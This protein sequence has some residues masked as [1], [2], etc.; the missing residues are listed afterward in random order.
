MAGVVASTRAAVLMA[1]L[2]LVLAACGS[3]PPTAPTTPGRT[4]PAFQ[5]LVFTKTAGFRHPSIPDA[6]NALHRLGRDHSFAVDN[7]ADATRITDAGLARYH[8]VV[9]LSTTG[10]ILNHTQQAALQRYIRLGGGWVGI[11]AAAAAEDAWPWYG[12]LVGARFRNHPAIQRA[13]IRV[14][15]GAAD[16][17]GVL[18]ARWERTD[19]W[20]NFRSNPRRHARVLAVVDET[21]YQGGTMGTDHP[22]AWCHDY[23]GGRA[24]YTA[25]GHTPASYHEPAFLTHLLAGIRYAAGQSRARCRPA[26]Q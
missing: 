10:D 19:E 20:Y 24:W 15:P 23:D 26:R 25:S 9:F 16:A 13:T 2:I 3:P 12:G 21:S 7:T 22:I 18:P 8:A 14:M 1:T 11:H 6:V 4:T 5:V 17:G